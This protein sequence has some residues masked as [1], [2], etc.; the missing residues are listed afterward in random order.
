MSLPSTLVTDAP[1]TITYAPTEAATD[2]NTSAAASGHD[3]SDNS[4]NN[5]AEAVP[6]IHIETDIL[7]L[8]PETVAE[9]GP[10]TPLETRPGN[11]ARAL[12]DAEDDDTQEKNTSYTDDLEAA[13][14]LVFRPLFRYRKHNNMRRR[15]NRNDGR[16][17]KDGA[18][19]NEVT[20]RRRPWTYCPP[21]RIYF[22]PFGF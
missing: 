22:Y 8:I 21:C 12:H 19:R 9:E 1:A 14:T 17:R 20:E 5:T 10:V 16:R 11:G 6:G 13:E 4:A 7:L 2:S 15:T 18:F 3:T